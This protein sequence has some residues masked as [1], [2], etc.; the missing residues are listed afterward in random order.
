M[1]N[2]Y[3]LVLNGSTIQELQTG[4]GLQLPIALAPQYGGTGIVNNAAS[5][6]AISGNYATTV[7]V[8]GVTTVTLP[9]SGVIA[10]R[11][12]AVAYSIIFGL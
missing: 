6:W 7:T 12:N 4:D 11:S 10:T 2:K 3:P 8:T 9:T 5:T 1:A